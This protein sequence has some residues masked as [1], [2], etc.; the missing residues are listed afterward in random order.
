[1]TSCCGEGNV[2]VSGFSYQQL[3]TA[4]IPQCFIYLILP[5]LSSTHFHFHI[6]I[7]PRIL[8]LTFF[9]LGIFVFGVFILSIF[10]LGIF[11]LGIFILTLCYNSPMSEAHQ[12]SDK[13]FSMYLVILQLRKL[14]EFFSKQVDNQHHHLI[15]VGSSNVN[16][17]LLKTNPLCPIQIHNIQ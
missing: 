12:T 1:M 7:H 16:K 3:T 17:Y 4:S 6:P 2:E 15:I 11:I 8:I 9:I 5:S 14:I 10:V 13:K